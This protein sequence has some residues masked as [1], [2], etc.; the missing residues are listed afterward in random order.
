[1]SDTETTVD[2]VTTDVETEIDTTDETPERLTEDDYFR[3]KARREKAEKALVEQKRRLKEL[4]SKSSD[5]PSDVM[6][7]AEYAMEKFLDKNPELSEYTKEL[8]EYTKKGLSLEDAKTLV[9]NSDKAKQ[10]REKTNSL[11]LSDWEASSRKSSYTMSELD[12]LASKDPQE[13][14][15][16]RNEM[17]AG[18]IK[19]AR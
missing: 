3:E 8:S 4:E 14:Y 10:N 17:D 12:K 18:K 2:D 13:Y 19:M 11:G 7:K 16:V 15:R 9:L 6:T 5:T 1:M